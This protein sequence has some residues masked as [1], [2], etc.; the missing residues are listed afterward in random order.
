M[1]KN[2]KRILKWALLSVFVAVIALGIVGFKMYTKPH[3]N[4]EAGKAVQISAFE[5]V[6][7]YEDNESAANSKYLDKILEVKGEVANVSKNQKG[8]PVVTLKGTDT[9]GL[10]CTLDEKISANLKPNTTVVIKGICT[11]YLTDVVL[12]RSIV[13]AE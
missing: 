10:I 1:K 7:N 8:E 12:V 11:G 2:R 5:L 13:Q 9:S 4:V 3:R 6:K